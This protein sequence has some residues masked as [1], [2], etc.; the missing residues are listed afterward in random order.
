MQDECDSW[1]NNVTV[2]EPMRKQHTNPAMVASVD[3][4]ATKGL[5][6]PHLHR[7][8]CS[9]HHALLPQR[10][11]SRRAHAG[12]VGRDA[13][14]HWHHHGMCSCGRSLAQA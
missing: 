10:P 7:I 6:R 14:H 13:E 2:K 11:H 5:R 1:I 3:R 4:A 12:A 9:R 8:P